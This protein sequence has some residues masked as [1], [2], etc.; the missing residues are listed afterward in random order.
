MNASLEDN[1]SV[2]WTDNMPWRYF[3]NSYGDNLGHFFEQRINPF[4]RG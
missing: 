2:E 4:Q 3:Q 1:D